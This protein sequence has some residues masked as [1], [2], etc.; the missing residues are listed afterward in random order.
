MLIKISRM[1]IKQLE[2]R[3]GFTFYKV[4]HVIEVHPPV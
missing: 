2:H 3:H 4:A 1:K